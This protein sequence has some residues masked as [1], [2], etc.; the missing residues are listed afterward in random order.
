MDLSGCVPT[1]RE[2]LFEIGHPGLSPAAMILLYAC[3]CLLQK[4][5]LIMLDMRR[6][7]L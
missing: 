5:S 6:R 7:H 4:K 2:E 1:L 3:V